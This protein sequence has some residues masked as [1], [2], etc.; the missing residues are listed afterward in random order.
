MSI[1]RGIPG[2][3]RGRRSQPPPL[4]HGQGAALCLLAPAWL[5]AAKP[6][7]ESTRIQTGQ[8]SALTEKDADFFSTT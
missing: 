1:L 2:A 6:L 3:Q 4:L 5:A 7:Q 8:A